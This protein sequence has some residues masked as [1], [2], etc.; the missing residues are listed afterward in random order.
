[1]G[2][3]AGLFVLVLILCANNCLIVSGSLA[4]H[5]WPM[6]M[7]VGRGWEGGVET[8]THISYANP[9]PSINWQPSAAAPSAAGLSSVLFY[10]IK[11]L[12]K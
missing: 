11:R 4:R 5:C 7:R 6:E 10:T 2:G 9:F 12:G 3:R 1:M 8:A